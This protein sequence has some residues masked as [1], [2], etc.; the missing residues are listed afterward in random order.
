[1]ISASDTMAPLAFWRH[2]VKLAV[3]D[4]S[5]SRSVRFSPKSCVRYLG[6]PIDPKRHSKATIPFIMRLINNLARKTQWRAANVFRIACTAFGRLRSSWNKMNNTA[7]LIPSHLF[8][9]VRRHVQQR[10]RTVTIQFG[11][12]VR[13][14]VRI[15]RLISLRQ[16]IGIIVIGHRC[17]WCCCGGGGF[18]TG[19]DTS[20]NISQVERMWTMQK[21][22]YACR[23][24]IVFVVCSHNHKPPQSATIILCDVDDGKGFILCEVWV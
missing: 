22:V 9:G 19:N 13:L 18:E 2:S 21:C 8:V 1:M 11:T 17:R 15:K 24:C 10:Q 3:I 4:R 20:T 12:I 7:I 14:Q 23:V 5:L 16:S 6:Y